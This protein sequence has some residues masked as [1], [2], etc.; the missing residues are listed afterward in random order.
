MGIPGFVRSP[1][2]LCVYFLDHSGIFK[3]GGMKQVEKR[4]NILAFFCLLNIGIAQGK[5]GLGG[6]ASSD[7]GPA[8]KSD[9]D[10][11]PVFRMAQRIVG[12][13][14]DLPRIILCQA[15]SELFRVSRLDAGKFPQFLVIRI[16][17]LPG[18]P[19][20]KDKL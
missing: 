5:G 3:L 4:R 16:V 10:D 20:L 6:E 18:F 9:D 14:S 1:F 11:G 19:V 15:S 13:G 12:K 7:G 17:C 8:C 2:F